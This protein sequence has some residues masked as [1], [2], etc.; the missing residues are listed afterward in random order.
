MDNEQE[1]D[2]MEQPANDYSDLIQVEA[3]VGEVPFETIKESIKTQFEDYINLE[4][5]TNY[6]DIFYEQMKKSYELLE[7]DPSEYRKTEVKE[8]L[9]RIKEEFLDFMC[10]QFETRLDLTI[11]DIDNEISN[12]DNLEWSIRKIYEY[13]ILNAKNNFKVVIA[14]DV[15]NRIQ[16]MI[17]TGLTSAD[18]YFNMITGIIETNYTPLITTITP[19]DFLKFSSEKDISDMFENGFITGNFL[20]KYS[21]KFYRNEEFQ[22]ELINYVTMVISFKKELTKDGNEQQPATATETS[23]DDSDS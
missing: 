12:I 9:T 23:N 18:E 21:P 11:S 14:K 1:Y 8:V 3:F 7:D 15:I 16:E 22:V 6:L 5:T 10:E 2:Y 17:D 4:D 20:R 19:T 13:F